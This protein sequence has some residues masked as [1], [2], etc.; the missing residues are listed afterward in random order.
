MSGHRR[1]FSA[2]FK[3]ETTD[4]VIDTVPPVDEDARE[5]TLD[6]ELVSVWNR[7]ERARL[8]S[9]TQLQG[10]QND[11]EIAAQTNVT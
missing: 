5:L 1:R 10:T 7:A 8:G 9:C 4:R 3:V 11:P 2:E 6:P